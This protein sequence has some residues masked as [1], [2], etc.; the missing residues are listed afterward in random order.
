MTE[1]TKKILEAIVADEGALLIDFDYAIC[2]CCG[3]RGQHQPQ[4]IITL[5]E[6]ELALATNG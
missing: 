6:E 4:C 3:D 1:K 2:N 5:A